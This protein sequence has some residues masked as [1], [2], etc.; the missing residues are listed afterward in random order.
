MDETCIANAKS[1]CGI[2]ILLERSEALAYSE[3]AS[4]EYL[5]M[6]DIEILVFG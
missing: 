5:I 6:L 4:I 3:H 1:E 2:G